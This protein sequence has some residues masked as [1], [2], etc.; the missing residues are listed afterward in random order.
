MQKHWGC[1]QSLELGTVSF[2][3]R[4]SQDMLMQK[5]LRR[6]K[7]CTGHGGHDW[8][9]LK[10]VQCVAPAAVRDGP[11]QPRTTTC[12]CTLKEQCVLMYKSFSLEMT[13]VGA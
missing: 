1:V 2:V 6:H 9:R 3:A 4:L 10:T 7:R 12:L 5:V 11:I 8:Q 13:H